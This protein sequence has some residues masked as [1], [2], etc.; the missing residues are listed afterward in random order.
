MKENQNVQCIQLNDDKEFVKIIDVN[1]SRPKLVNKP[2]MV[3]VGHF[4]YDNNVYVANK[5]EG[6]AIY[7]AE[8]K[9]HV[10]Q[11]NSHYHTTTYD[12]LKGYWP[13][14]K[15]YIRLL[16]FGGTRITSDFDSDQYEIN[17]KKRVT[18]SEK[19]DFVFDPEIVPERVYLP[20]QE[21]VVGVKYEKRGNGCVVV[22]NLLNGKGKKEIPIVC[23][24]DDAARSFP[25]VWVP[26]E[27]KA[28]L[29][30]CFYL[31]K[32]VV[33]VLTCLV[34]KDGK[35]EEE[36]FYRAPTCVLNPNNEVSELATETAYPNI[37]RAESDKLNGILIEYGQEGCLFQLA[38]GNVTSV[39]VVAVEKYA[40]GYDF[41][42]EDFIRRNNDGSYGKFKFGD[43]DKAFSKYSPMMSFGKQVFVM[44][45]KKHAFISRTGEF[46][47]ES[48]DYDSLVDYEFLPFS[49]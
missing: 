33:P 48:G 44:G 12:A 29:H 43:D 46:T 41:V 35:F 34:Y 30:A 45:N 5:E 42:R 8:G 47:I 10:R 9:F 37:L 13:P 36:F 6:C 24:P 28:R 11:G 21:T 31:Y 20:V 7:N 40:R 23:Q 14:R 1:C 39:K 27:K 49:I 26:A 22:F 2:V 16:S 25:L 3:Y 19:Y 38:N 4:Y 17:A 18:W 15:G 32:N